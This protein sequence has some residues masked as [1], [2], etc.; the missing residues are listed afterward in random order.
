MDKA[1]SFARRLII[2]VLMCHFE[3]RERE[4]TIRWTRSTKATRSIRILLHRN[5]EKPEKIQAVPLTIQNFFHWHAV[6]FTMKA[7]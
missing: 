4:R 5:T 1:Y 2:D 3:I 7:K 6:V